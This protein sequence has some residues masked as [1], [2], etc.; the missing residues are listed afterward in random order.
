MGVLPLLMSIP[1]GS[2]TI[3]LGGFLSGYFSA[4]VMFS[5]INA[6]VESVGQ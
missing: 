3:R 6:K 2:D 4:V 5:L 1:V